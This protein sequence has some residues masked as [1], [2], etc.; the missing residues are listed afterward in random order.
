MKEKQRFEGNSMARSALLF[1]L[2]VRCEGDFLSWISRFHYAKCAFAIP[3]SETMYVFLG[4][5]ASG[6]VHSNLNSH[7]EES[8]FFCL[9]QNSKFRF[10]NGD[11]WMI[12]RKRKNKEKKNAL[13]MT[14][15][16]VRITQ[17]RRMKGRNCSK[18]KA[19]WMLVRS[20]L[21]EADG[22]TWKAFE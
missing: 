20:T 1:V 18:R 15:V 12:Q 11:A 6:I 13:C 19:V 21:M 5:E 4:I 8:F 10:R 3:N 17:M 2:S 22:T 7:H 16:H 14:I 9:R